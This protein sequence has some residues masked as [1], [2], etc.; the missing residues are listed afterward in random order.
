M[1]VRTILQRGNDTD[2]EFAHRLKKARRARE[3]HMRRLREAKPEFKAKRAAYN[4]AY[5]AK[6]ASEELERKRKWR[7]AN[8]EHYNAYYRKYDELTPGRRE[9]KARWSRERRAS[10]QI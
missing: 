4:R 10:A 9:Y 6:R 1:R 2:L 7:E 8:R 3:L 5:R